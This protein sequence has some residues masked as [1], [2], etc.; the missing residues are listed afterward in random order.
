M[1]TDEFFGEKEL[2]SNCDCGGDY[3]SQL[4]VMETEAQYDS[5]DILIFLEFVVF[6]Q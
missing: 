2:F 4:P 6:T 3:V 1:W 5:T